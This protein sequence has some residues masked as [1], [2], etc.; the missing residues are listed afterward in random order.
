MLDDDM[1][2]RV[3]VR[4]GTFL[5]DVLVLILL[6]ASRTWTDTRDLNFYYYVQVPRGLGTKK[7]ILLRAVQVR[8]IHPTPDAHPLRY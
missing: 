1:V 2:V 7:G 6:V 4:V 8:T 3:Q 5:Q